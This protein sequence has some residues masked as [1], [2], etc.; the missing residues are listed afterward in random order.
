VNI[1]RAI[2]LGLTVRATGMIQHAGRSTGVAS[3]EIRGVD[4][5]KLYA[6]GSTTCLIMQ[7]P[8]I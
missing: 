5:G 7:A 6:S 8:Q 4:D 3:G 1:T 2:P